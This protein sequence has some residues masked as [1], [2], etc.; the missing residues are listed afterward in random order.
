MVFSHFN[1]L[2]SVISVY[3]SVHDFQSYQ[4]L[5]Q[6][7][8]LS[9][10]FSAW[11]SHMR[12]AAMSMDQYMDFSVWISVCISAVFELKLYVGKIWTFTGIFS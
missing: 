1:A 12:V 3:G 4:S 7:I 5:V 6:C 8:S 2:F 11:F 9:N 10:F